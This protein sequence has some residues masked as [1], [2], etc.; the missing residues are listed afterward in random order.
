M[1]STIFVIKNYSHCSIAC[2]TCILLLDGVKTQLDIVDIVNLQKFVISESVA[3]HTA[4]HEM[5]IKGQ[6]QGI[7][8]PIRRYQIDHMNMPSA[9]VNQMT[10]QLKEKI[11]GIKKMYQMEDS[12]LEKYFGNSDFI[13]YEDL[14]S[15]QDLEF[16]EY[17]CNKDFKRL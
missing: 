16:W 5:I 7:D 3:R 10:L 1:N 2:Q 9:Q 6:E 15:S 4:H 14:I 13:R 11:A 17:L 12:V 8:K